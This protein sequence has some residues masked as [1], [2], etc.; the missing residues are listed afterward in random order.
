MALLV[1]EH[2]EKTYDGPAVRDVSLT[3]AEGEILCLLGPSGCGK[4][5]LLRLVAGLE[6]PDRGKVFFQGKEVT[7][8]P[9]HQRHFGLMFQ[10]FAL[11][12]HKSV[13]ENV[14]FGL[15]ML[16]YDPEQIRRR[17]ED[18]LEL[19]GLKPMGDRNV[20]DLSGGERQRVALARSL[21]PQ[22]RLLMLDEPLG[23]LDRTLRERLLPE[24][25]TILKQ[26]GMTAIFV[27]HDQSEALA[28]ADR[29]AV[30]N[31]GR[32]VQVDVPEDLYRY[33]GSVF[34]ARFLGFENLLSGET[35][36]DGSVDTRLGLLHPLHRSGPPPEPGGAVTLVLRPEG[37]RLAGD[38]NRGGDRPAIEGRIVSR[39][40]SG[41]SYR[42]R[43]AVT[44]DL[45]L[46][47]DLPNDPPPPSVGERVSLTLQRPNMVVI[48][49][50]S[51]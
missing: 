28:V 23:S 22:P 27:T 30:M 32:L 26:L 49:G 35:A 40:F 19:V 41:Q 33:P 8:M 10:E 15:H 48:P 46:V 12:P 39:L 14:A 16:G 18:M 1:L 4:T 29:V 13:F 9:P 42:V 37:A 44:G 7:R 11:F 45:T 21:A 50:A 34:V 38:G 5:T 47:F 24:I 43:I 25:H 17:T 36:A 20:A 2:L 3:L 31:R 51:G 6:P